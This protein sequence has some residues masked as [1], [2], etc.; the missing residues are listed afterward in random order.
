M[1]A[2][3]LKLV[4]FMS[5]FILLAGYS[6]MVGFT[7]QMPASTDHQESISSPK[8][9]QQGAEIFDADWSIRTTIVRDANLNAVVDSSED[10]LFEHTVHIRYDFAR[11]LIVNPVT[12]ERLGTLDPETHLG[13]FM[14]CISELRSCT[15][16]RATELLPNGHPGNWIV[17]NMPVTLTLPDGL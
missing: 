6:S 4:G 11:N 7:P 1:I 8:P 12:G 15:V 17:S 5:L 2:P 16:Y 9:M 14:L 3:W 13:Q 10:V